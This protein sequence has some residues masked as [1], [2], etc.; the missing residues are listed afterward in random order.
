MSVNKFRNNTTENENKHN[1]VRHAGP[2]ALA[3]HGGRKF[4][5][6][7]YLRARQGRLNR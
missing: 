1:N 2:D 5:A 7:H 6:R 4:K 3:E